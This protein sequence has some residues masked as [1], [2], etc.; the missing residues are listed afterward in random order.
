MSRL[1]L[2]IQEVGSLSSS[3]FGSHTELLSLPVAILRTLM[4]VVDPQTVKWLAANLDP[5]FG[6]PSVVR[7][8]WQ[9]AQKL[10]EERAA[11]VSW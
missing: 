1:V 6:F 11:K 8:S 7:F 2:D 4:S 10:L 5:V 3:S 9:T